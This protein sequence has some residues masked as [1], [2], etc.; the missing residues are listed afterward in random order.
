M[1]EIVDNYSFNKGL[2]FIIDREHKTLN[3]Q[4]INFPMKI[5][6]YELNR[7]FSKEELQMASTLK[8]VQLLLLKNRCNQNA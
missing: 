1:G 6:T 2:I 3:P 8:T 7:K 5:W 4:R